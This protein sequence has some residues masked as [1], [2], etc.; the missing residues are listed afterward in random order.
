MIDNAEY[1]LALIA[2]V[3]RSPELYDSS[4][5]DFRCSDIK[6]D[7]WKEIAH[8]LRQNS[9]GHSVKMVRS[10]WKSLR[11][12]LVKE[13]RHKNT[14]HQ[15]DSKPKRNWRYYNAMAFLLPYLGEPNPAKGNRYR[16]R[17]SNNE[18]VEPVEKYL[19]TTEDLKQI[20]DDPVETAMDNN[21]QDEI[22][23]FFKGIADT[24]KKLTPENQVKVQ[25]EI[26]NMVLD[27][28]L[29]EI[30]ETKDPSD[31]PSE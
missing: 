11:D 12:T 10:R 8:R 16:K 28:K 25:R 21:Q 23:S 5:M 7:K 2:E 4:H 24:V 18:L 30:N 17:I 29:W 22:D 15:P 19:I 13:T 14:L 31:D 27:I 3:E 9:D 26:V 6:M 20:V 1:D